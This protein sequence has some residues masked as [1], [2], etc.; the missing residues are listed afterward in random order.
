MTEKTYEDIIRECA[1]TRR[2]L[3]VVLHPTY[4]HLKKAFSLIAGK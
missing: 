1:E 3:D 4:G 2:D